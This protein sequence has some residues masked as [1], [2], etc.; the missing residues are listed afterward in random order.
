[1]SNIDLK[2]ITASLTGLKIGLDGL[3]NYK[4]ALQSIPPIS[5][6]IYSPDLLS[7][8][9]LSKERVKTTLDYKYDIF[10]ELPGKVFD[11][12]YNRQM[13]SL[14]IEFQSK[15]NDRLLKNSG[16]SVIPKLEYNYDE[17]EEAEL[18]RMTSQW[19]SGNAMLYF[20]FEKDPEESNFGMI[21]NDNL[22]RNYHTRSGNLFLSKSNDVIHEAIDFIFRVYNV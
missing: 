10:S 17:G 11:K 21:W 20:S 1:M 6:S 3:D 19:D 2:G 9:S 16:D 8:F 18:I 15:F 4:S 13:A 14:M 12:T 7:G 5:P 22:Y